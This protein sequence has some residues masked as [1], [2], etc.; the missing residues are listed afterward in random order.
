MIGV[1][2]R[3]VE[4]DHVMGERHRGVERGGTGMVAEL[5]VDP[6]YAGAARLFDGHLGRAFHD[7]VA[8]AVVAVQDGRAGVLVHDM[9]VRPDVEA[10][11][12]DPPDILRQP[13]DAVPVR[14]L[15][16]GRRHQGRDRRSVGVR[17]AYSNERL[18][19]EGL[20]PA[21]SN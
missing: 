2:D 17:Q 11:G 8:H 12:L 18:L 15:Q 5:R 13:A 16:V 10:A 20:Q 6:A 3:K 21:K 19:N 4:P 1:A 7:E 14:P 9:D